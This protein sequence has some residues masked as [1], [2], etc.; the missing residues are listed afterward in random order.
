MPGYNGITIGKNIYF[1][2][3][4]YDPSTAEGLSLL[5]HELV[6]VDQFRAGLTLRKYLWSA[7]NGYLNSPYERSAYAEEAEILKDLSDDRD[8]NCACHQ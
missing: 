5:G 8:W 3:G 2:Q 4:Y 1:R 7:R 6:H